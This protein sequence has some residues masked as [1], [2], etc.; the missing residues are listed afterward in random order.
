MRHRI[1]IVGRLT[2]DP[3]LRYTSEGV[4]VAN[5]TVAVD[6]GFGERKKTLW[7]KVS[8]WRKLAETCN[9]YLKKGRQVYVEGRLN[10]DETGNPR[11]YTK[12]DGSPGAQFEVTA[13]EVVFLGNSGDNEA[14]NSGYEEPPVS[15]GA[16]AQVSDDPMPF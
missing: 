11:T 6:D 14:G 9:Q 3:E 10:A 5:F 4:P 16:Q 12:R 2:R 8:V 7:I 13:S 15:N 1:I